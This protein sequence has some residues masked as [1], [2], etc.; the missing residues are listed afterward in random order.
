MDGNAEDLR[1]R[2]I[3]FPSWNGA[4]TQGGSLLSSHAP[5][6]SPGIFDLNL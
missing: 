6:F 4:L 1:P 5:V 2:L 3:E